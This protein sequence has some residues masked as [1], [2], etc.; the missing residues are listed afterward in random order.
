MRLLRYRKSTGCILE[1][2]VFSNGKV[3]AS[4]TDHAPVREVAV[5][6][7]LLDFQVVRTKE[8]GYTLIED[9]KLC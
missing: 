6:D 3:A 4:W 7:C 5:Y 1:V 8:R 2:F 9:M